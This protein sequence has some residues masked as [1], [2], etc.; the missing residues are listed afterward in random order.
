MGVDAPYVINIIH[1]T[2]PSSLKAYMQQI[3]HAGCTGLSSCVTLYYNNSDFENNKKPCTTKSHCRSE[4]TC[5]RKLL[6]D[7]FGFSSVQQDNCCCICDGKFKITE[8]D[9][10]HIVISK[11]R[12]LSNDNHVILER[13]IKS[14]ISESQVSH[15]I[16]DKID[17]FILWHRNF[18]IP[19]KIALRVVVFHSFMSSCSLFCHYLA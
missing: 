17:T 8:E 11:V 10:P 15:Q 6:L 12:F 19:S 1:I 16:G 9:L 3:G 4:D 7:Y 13:I 14:V 18:L 5:Q 2:L